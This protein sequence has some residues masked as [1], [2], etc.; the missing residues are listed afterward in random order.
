V[1]KE[2]HCHILSDEPPE[3][4]EER[5]EQGFDGRRDWGDA[6]SVGAGDDAI[7]VN[8]AVVQPA[9]IFQCGIVRFR[10]RERPSE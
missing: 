1:I 2:P 5:G 9:N 10:A 3:Y 4:V 6:M 8:G 7:Q